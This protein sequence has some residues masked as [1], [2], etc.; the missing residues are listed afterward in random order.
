MKILKVIE[1]MLERRRF[2]TGLFLLLVGVVIGHVL[3]RIVYLIYFLVM[4]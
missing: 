2:L 3:C 4:T 1:D